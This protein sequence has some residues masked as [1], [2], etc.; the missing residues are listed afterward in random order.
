MQPAPSPRAALKRRAA[1]RGVSLASLSAQIGRNVTYLQQYLDR[2]SPKRLPEDDRR[3]LAIALNIDER[4]LGAREP[5]RP[6][7]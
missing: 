2:G 6:A 3:H 7:S 1:E 4:E 5:W